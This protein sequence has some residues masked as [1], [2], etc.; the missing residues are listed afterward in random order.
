MSECSEVLKKTPLSSWHE[1]HGAQMVPFAGYSM[2][3]RY[4]QI[5][6]EHHHVRAQA[7]LFDVSHMGELRLRG[8][9]A[10]ALANRLHTNDARRGLPRKAEAPVRAL[11]GAI[12]NEAGG[13]LDDV[14]VYPFAEDDVLFCVNAANVDKIDAWLRAH[15][16]GDVPLDNESEAT[17][18]IAVQGPRAPQILARVFPHLA[19]MRPMRFVRV[20]WR[21]AELTVATS[22]YTGEAGGEIFLPNSH[23]LE[24]WETLLAAGEPGEVGPFLGRAT[25]ER[26]MEHGP[27]RRLRGIAMLERGIPR[28]GYAVRTEH[29]PG[30]VTS[31][32]LA[33][34][35][36]RSIALCYLPAAV[37]LG[38]HV[39]V[40]MRGTWRAAEVVKVPFEALPVS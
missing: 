31:G 22:G 7:G 25:I 12:C 15:L 35:L 2:P 40:E 37:S 23:A 14:I 3:V 5:T 32:T 36:Q 30:V 16:E 21:G 11:Y 13:I 9:G 39:E 29:G 6:A 26:Q 33:P 1:A 8:P 28:H 27:S 18:Q 34:S 10:L 38:D 19:P 17:A 20:A 4:G 24:L